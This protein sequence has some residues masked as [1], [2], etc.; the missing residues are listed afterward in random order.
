MDA[1]GP[2]KRF[3]LLE[4]G[5]PGGERAG[6]VAAL[7]DVH[8]QIQTPIAIE[9]SGFG[10]KGIGQALPGGRRFEGRG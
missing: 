9:I 1:P 5:K 4:P 6:V 2:I 8:H 3:R 10:L 7:N